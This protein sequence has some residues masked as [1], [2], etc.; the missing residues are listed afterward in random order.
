MSTLMERDS[1]YVANTYRRFPVEVVSGKG[2]L[3]WDTD[4]KRYID[5]GSGIGVTAFGI[6][7][8]AWQAA[9]TA[10][11]GRVLRWPSGC[12]SAPV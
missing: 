4:G 11:L 8:D 3:L 1:A 9:V 12:A 7:D 10:Q 6:A 5:L 2:S